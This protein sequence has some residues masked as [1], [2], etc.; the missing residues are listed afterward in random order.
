L[1]RSKTTKKKKKTK[2]I[3]KMNR[4]FHHLQ[5]LT[6]IA[7]AVALAL[8]SCGG[9]DNDDKA[10]PAT[11]PPTVAPEATTPPTTVAAEPTSINPCELVTQADAKQLIPSA[12]F[13]E[14][15]LA[16]PEGDQSCTYAGQPTG[17]TAQVESYAGPGAKKYLDIDQQLDHEFTDVS[18]VGDEAHLEDLNIFFRKGENWFGIRIVTL[19]DPAPYNERLKTLAATV[20]D[21]L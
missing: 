4:R 7:L 12:D 9:D 6:L 2:G 17:P 10:T 13:Q 15:V 19:D 1:T 5:L 16:G 21:K 3:R 11:T 14:A 8:A 18:G 20:A